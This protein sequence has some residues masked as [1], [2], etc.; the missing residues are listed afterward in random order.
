[1]S[2]LPPEVTRLR[3]QFTEATSISLADK[4]QFCLVST[5]FTTEVILTSYAC[6]GLTNRLVRGNGDSKDK[7]ESNTPILLLH[8]FDSSL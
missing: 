8:G 5:S 6:D 4:I 3:S 7:F 2:N 1:M